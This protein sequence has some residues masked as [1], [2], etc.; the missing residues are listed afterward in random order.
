VLEDT[1]SSERVPFMAQVIGKQ[2]AY[3]LIDQM[4]AE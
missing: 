1:L 2:E 4:P 3:D